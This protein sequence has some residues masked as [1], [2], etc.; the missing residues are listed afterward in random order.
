MRL[1]YSIALYALSPLFVLHLL[2]RGLRAPD[3][4][5]RWGERFG[6][7]PRAKVGGALWLHAVSVGEFQATLPLIH[8]L[9]EGHPDLPLLVTTTTPTGS[10]R[11]LEALDD[12]VTHVYAPYD[13]PCAVRRFL[14]VYRPCAALF[15]ETEIWPNIYAQCEQRGIPLILANAR[16]SEHS[17]R[18]YAR[19]GRLTRRTLQCVSAVAAQTEV[20]ARRLIALGAPEERVRVTGSVKF[21]VSLPAS[22]QEQ[23]QVLRRDWGV[24]RPVWIA[25]STHAGEDEIVLDAFALLRERIA[26]ALLVLVPRHPERFDKV[27]ALCEKRAF[28]MIRRSTHMACAGQCDIFLGDTMGELPM[29][30][31]AS[32]V[33][34]V[35]GSLFALGGHNP[36][37]AAALGLPVL[38]GPHGFNFQRINELLAEAGALYVV[39]N[40]AQLAERV[41]AWLADANLRHAHG[42]RGREVVEANRGALRALLDMIDERIG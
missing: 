37:E 31:A 15:M 9:R 32:D 34:F 1:L 35:G 28:K 36:L 11:V 21:D 5:R 26:N 25:A 4:W 6:F 13:L 39:K 17:A 14:S 10:R 7:P 29:F 41:G 19:L 24:G 18:G 38:S 2:W 12:T 22:L 30:Y 20:D 8:A 40:A 42:E 23:A 3:Y 16:M 27:A 33:A